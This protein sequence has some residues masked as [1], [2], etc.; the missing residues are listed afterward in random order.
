VE[1]YQNIRISAGPDDSTI[2]LTFSTRIGGNQIMP[3]SDI[4]TLLEK[5]HREVKTLLETIISSCEE[6]GKIDFAKVRK[7]RDALELHTKIEEKHLY[8]KAEKERD[9]SQLIADAYKEHDEVKE[10]LKELKDDVEPD[11]IGKYCKLILV[12]VEHHVQEEEEELFPLLREVWDKDTLTELGE[13]AA[14]MKDQAVAG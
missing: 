3:K 10:L 13:K 2:S 6:K 14:Q 5:D 4:L 11:E 7:V 9:A 12:S 8:P 1:D